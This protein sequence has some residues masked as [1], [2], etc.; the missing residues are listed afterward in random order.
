METK[1]ST[2]ISRIGFSG[3]ILGLFLT[4]GMLNHANAQQN[5]I[6]DN[7]FELGDLNQYWAYTFTHQE[8]SKLS[9]V[10]PHSGTY[11]LELAG[12]NNTANPTTDRDASRFQKLATPFIV[13]ATYHYS[14]WIN[15]GLA[16]GRSYIGIQFLDATGA[17]LDDKSYDANS[18]LKVNEWKFYEATFV[19]PAGAVSWGPFAYV[20]GQA[21][22]TLNSVFLDDFSLE[23]VPQN[24]IDNPGFETA[25]LLDD[26]WNGVGST[27]GTLSFV[28]TNTPHAGTHCL[29][30]GSPTADATRY[31]QIW[32]AIPGNTYKYSFWVNRGLG[33]ADSYIGIGF[34][35]IDG[36]NVGDNSIDAGSIQKSADWQYF[37]ASFVYTPKAGYDSF[38]PFIYVNGSGTNTIL[39]DDFTL[40]D[41][42][43]QTGV[44]ALPESDL[45]LY[46]N[47]ISRGQSLT[48]N[49]NGISGEKIVSMYDLSGR[50]I[51]S[52]KLQNT[53]SQTL[54]ID[55]KVKAGS[56]FVR[57]ASGKK[58]TSKLLIIR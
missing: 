57:I 50:M 16:G 36:N 56:Y 53:D 35:D 20:E 39:L 13:G 19:M 1:K 41:M 4:V 30:I 22:T 58:I 46:P 31:Q 28:S 10:N 5:I 25:G 54:E 38:G 15:R 55:S 23:F 2:F 8:H 11:C 24:M 17:Y 51:F 26:T 48:I 21:A 40:L 18:I 42:G 47:P 12:W 27:D 6:P 44:K 14:F 32:G 7:G 29:E 45:K 9:T 52:K 3:L 49:T 37:E 33:G 34:F 43:V